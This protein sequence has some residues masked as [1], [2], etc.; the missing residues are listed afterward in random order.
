MHMSTLPG[1]WNRQGIPA[2]NFLLPRQA[3]ELLL[4][5]ESWLVALAKGIYRGACCKYVGEVLRKL[6]QSSCVEPVDNGG[7]YLNYKKEK[8]EKKNGS[9][10]L[11]SHSL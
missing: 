7:H 8:A 11:L 2:I 6:T 9:E 1:F 3:A 10:F 5:G 4:I